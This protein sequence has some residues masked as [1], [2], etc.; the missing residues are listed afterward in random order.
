MDSLNALAGVDPLAQ[1]QFRAQP[2]FVRAGLMYASKYSSVHAQPP[3][4]R[5][6][7]CELLKNQ[8]SL[9]FKNTDLVAALRFYEEA[10]TIF[11]YVHVHARPASAIDFTANATDLTYIDENGTL[12]TCQISTNSEYY[13]SIFHFSNLSSLSFS[14]SYSLIPLTSLIM[15][16][17]YYLCVSAWRLGC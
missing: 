16:E 13:L 3:A 14:L 10:L 5:V 6:F 15:N 9:E 2:R 12:S 7:A 11:R 17:N 4:L 1:Q 8:G